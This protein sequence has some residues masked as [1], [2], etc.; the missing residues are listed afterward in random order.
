MADRWR[1]IPTSW[2]R[3]LR[4]Q[5]LHHRA[6]RILITLHLV[7]DSDT[8]EAHSARDLVLV[9]GLGLRAD[10]ARDSLAVLEDAGFI[11]RTTKGSRLVDYVHT[12]RSAAGNTRAQRR[13]STGARRGHTRTRE[14]EGSREDT[15]PP[16]ARAHS[17]INPKGFIEREV[18]PPDGGHP[19]VSDEQK[20]DRDRRV[21]A[22]NR[23][24]GYT[25]KKEG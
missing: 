15:Q 5:R 14:T 23:M 8:I 7:A 22:I 3:D 12:R 2:A 1:P 25:R 4:F 16:L 20:A 19:P 9:A 18:R 24:L 10:K 17:E 13:G 6:M 21:A 11:E